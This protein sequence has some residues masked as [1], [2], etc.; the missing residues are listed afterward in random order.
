MLALVPFER[1]FSATLPWFLSLFIR[2]SLKIIGWS[3][4]DGVSHVETVVSHLGFGP[5]H[6]EKVGFGIKMQE[7]RNVP[8]T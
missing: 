5:R 6:V 7:I 8:K 2:F 4:G 1:V 3:G